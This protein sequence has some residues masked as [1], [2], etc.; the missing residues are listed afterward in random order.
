MYSCG[1]TTI[2]ESLHVECP[3]VRAKAYL[4]DTL[5]QACASGAP[6]RLHLT[7][8]LPGT[9]IEFQKTVLVHYGCGTDPMHF[10]EPWIVNWEAEQG[11]IYPSFRGALTVR[12][13]EDYTG[14]ILELSGAYT[15]P[16]G[17]AG[18]VFDKALGQK[19]AS[20]TMQTLLAQI[21]GEMLERYRREEAAKTTSL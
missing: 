15:P 16:L 19:I 13:D 18:S 3:Y 4:H 5:A 8:P 6:Q 14:A 10:D 17:V 12:A 11:G 1:M 20:A 9:Q 7:A 21:A 2:K